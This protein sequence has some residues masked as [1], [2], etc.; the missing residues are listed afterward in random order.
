MYIK[1][2]LKFRE[3]EYQATIYNSLPNRIAE[4]KCCGIIY[5]PYQ[6]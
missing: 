3:V 1:V 2:Q 5:Q 6:S 4:F